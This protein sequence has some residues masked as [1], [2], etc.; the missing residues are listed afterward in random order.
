MTGGDFVN[1]GAWVFDGLEDRGGI[2]VGKHAD[3]VP[4]DPERIAD[5]VT[6]EQPRQACDGIVGVRVSG[7]LCWHQGAAIGSRSGRFLTH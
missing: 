3:P 7:E 5:R 2:E 1:T 4:F 6:C